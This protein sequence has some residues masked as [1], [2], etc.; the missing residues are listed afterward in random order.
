MAGR[1]GEAEDVGE[2]ARV[3]VGDGPGQPRHLGREHDLRRDD[4]FDVEQLLLERRLLGPLQQPAVDELAGEAHL[5]PRA[6]LGALVELGRHQVVERAVEVR[7]R[8]VHANASDRQ[9]W[10]RLPVARRLAGRHR[11]ILPAVTLRRR[12]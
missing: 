11:A 12:T 9:P 6:R 3:A 1:D 10:S 5:D 8:D 4:L 7:E 2:V